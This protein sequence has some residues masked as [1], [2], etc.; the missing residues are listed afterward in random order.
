MPSRSEFKV[1]LIIS[2][3][4]LHALMVEL[5]RLD[6][7]I[8][9]IEP[10]EETRRVAKMKSKGSKT[11]PKKSRFG[12]PGHKAIERL[13]NSGLTSITQLR[14][15]FATEGRS[16]AS[17]DSALQDAKRRNLVKVL[18]ARP[19]RGGDAQLEAITS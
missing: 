16:R 6:V 13:V 3:R 18:R 7:A 19:G 15:A 17:V 4:R 11:T 8:L 12:E 5:K 9:D 14:D 10:I 1:Q 2:T